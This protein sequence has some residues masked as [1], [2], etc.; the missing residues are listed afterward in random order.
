M[1]S[2]KGLLLSMVKDRKKEFGS[3]ND[4]EMAQKREGSMFGRDAAADGWTHLPFLYLLNV[5][6]LRNMGKSQ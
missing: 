1:L 5:F 3:R 4:D 6:V 2:S